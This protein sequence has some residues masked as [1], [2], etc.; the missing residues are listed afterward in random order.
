M[1]VLILTADSNGGYPV[2]AVR[3]GAISTLIEHLVRE[4]NENQLCDMEIVSLHDKDA[5]KKAREE[6]PN[7]SFTWIKAPKIIKALD[8]LAFEFVQ[9]ARKN[10]KAISFKTPFSL[11]YFILKAKKMVKSTN[12]DKIVL[13]NNIPLV[14]VM[15][16]SSFKGQ[17]YY[18]L[19]NVPR[20]DAGC[21]NEF[22]KI[23]KFLCV[24]QFVADQICSEKSAIGQ[25]EPERTTVLKNCVDI[26]KF[27]PLSK[28]DLKIQELKNKFTFTDNEFIVIFS[29]RLSEEKGVDIVIK[30]VKGLPENVRLLVVGSLFS[31]N[32]T[33][34][35]Y[36]AYLTALANDLNDRIVFTGYVDQ[37]EMP[38]MYNLADI[39]VLPS[40]WEEPA[41]LTMVEALACGIPVITTK[42]GGIPEYMKDKAIILSKD[43]NLVDN[44]TKTITSFIKSKK[45]IEAKSYIENNFSPKVFVDSFLKIV[46]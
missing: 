12:A 46:S 21:R 9:V 30:A 4:N 33:H 11:L 42:S 23:T 35:P 14:R 20:I 38:Y 19:H 15:K 16:N 43:E 36:Q 27:R 3:G 34:T 18:H 22:K 17:W 37:K 8:S 24:S 40:M 2:P 32:N 1:K 44:L 6:Y 31:S 5:E 13:E 26:E 25:I 29:G 28:N 39:A 41:G 10:E 45:S 7:I